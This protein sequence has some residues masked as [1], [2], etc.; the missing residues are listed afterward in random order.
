MTTLETLY[1]LSPES[2]NI[3]GLVARWALSTLD[4]SIE[5]VTEHSDYKLLGIERIHDD[6]SPEK[7]D[8]RPS[9]IIGSPLYAA[10]LCACFRKHLT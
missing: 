7:N 9:N 2:S 5:H 8:D 4:N 6:P 3:R 10:Y 1:R